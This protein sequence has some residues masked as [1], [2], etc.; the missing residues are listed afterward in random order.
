MNIN[1]TNIIINKQYINF[2]K[3]CITLLEL[4]YDDKIFYLYPMFK[5][6]PIGNPL[7]D[8]TKFYLF[9]EINNELNDFANYKDIL[10]TNNNFIKTNLFTKCFSDCEITKS[11]INNEIESLLINKRII[12]NSSY[13]HKNVKIKSYQR[14]IF[15]F[16][17]KL[18]YENIKK[19]KDEFETF[20]KNIETI[21]NLIRTESEY[22]FIFT[23]II[24]IITNLNYIE[25]NI[26][27]INFEDFFNIC[28]YFDDMRIFLYK[29]LV[30]KKQLSSE[31]FIKKTTKNLPEYMNLIE[32]IF[33]FDISFDKG[34]QIF[35]DHPIDN[36]VISLNFSS[37]NILSNFNNYEIFTKIVIRVILFLNYLKHINET[38]PD[39]TEDYIVKNKKLLY[40]IEENKEKFHE[41]FHKIIEMV[42][43]NCNFKPY[44]LFDK[45][46]LYVYDE[47]MKKRIL[48]LQ[49]I[50]NYIPTKMPDFFSHI[51]TENKINE[52]EIINN[53]YCWNMINKEYKIRSYAIENEDFQIMNINQTIICLKKWS[54]IDV[55]KRFYGKKVKYIEIVKIYDF[56]LENQNNDYTCI[57]IYL[58]NN[59]LYSIIDFKKFTDYGLQEVQ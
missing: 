49:T 27:S 20:K 48:F 24:K 12:L 9:D 38:Y 30:D 28:N 35:D 34:M 8:K 17:K 36:T 45:N 54:N 53:S 58:K 59:S 6:L 1:L 44:N 26:I 52:L 5:C 18:E 56:I 15:P 4:M 23:E 16:S 57:G 41:L 43:Q 2:E 47:N 14:Y 37:D 29:K 7:I 13:F 55:L 32:N 42:S 22:M 25:K 31:N 50:D 33:K 3:G 19:A 11:V 21:E 46:I 39:N 40:I 51:T 10:S